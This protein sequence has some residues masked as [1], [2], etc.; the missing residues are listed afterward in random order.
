MYDSTISERIRRQISN[1]VTA[2]LILNETV[3]EQDEIEAA[4]T[5]IEEFGP[6][7]VIP[8][9]VDGVNIS[10]V[11]IV[12]EVF[13]PITGSPTIQ[14]TMV[15]SAVPTYSPSTRSPT[16]PGDTFSPSLLPTVKPSG[17]PSLFPT[18]TAPTSLL[19]TFFPTVGP[20]SLPT[21][22]PTQNV[23]L[24]F[25]TSGDDFDLNLLWFLVFLIPLALCM[26]MMAGRLETKKRK[27]STVSKH[28]H[29]LHSDPSPDD[30]E[31]FLWDDFNA[32]PSDGENVIDF[33]AYSESSQSIHGFEQHPLPLPTSIGQS[34]DLPTVLHGQ[35]D[36]VVYEFAQPVFDTETKWGGST[37]FESERGSDWSFKS[38][39]AARLKNIQRSDGYDELVSESIN[40]NLT[41]YG[42]PTTPSQLRRPKLSEAIYD[43]GEEEE[44]EEIDLEALGSRDDRAKEIAHQ[45]FNRK[46][47]NLFT[48]TL[49]G[50]SSVDGTLPKDE[51]FQW[52]DA[53]MNH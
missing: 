30:S 2:N 49:T 32:D 19:P 48:R 43:Y 21:M 6:E 20:T 53:M 41:D 14:P 37:K 23:N 38:R 8:I 44:D 13:V 24:Y 29:R 26:G 17:V 35:R 34:D 9:V 3:I 31:A 47:S 52:D 36:E 16:L 11:V 51:S 40:D 15:P 45:L 42:V 5:S 46:M 27:M 25:T 18:S 50:E 10:P 1:T 33:A 4:I 28:G 7:V 22:S 12:E 39:E